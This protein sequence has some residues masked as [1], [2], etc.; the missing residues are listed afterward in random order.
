MDVTPGVNAQRAKMTEADRDATALVKAEPTVTGFDDLV[1]A[2]HKLSPQRSIASIRRG[3]RHNARQLDDDGLWT[4]RYDDLVGPSHGLLDR[5]PEQFDQLW[6]D[7]A[8]IT[9]PTLLLLGGSSNM[10]EPTMSNDSAD[11]FGISGSKPLPE[12]VTLFTARTRSE[13]L[14]Y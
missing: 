7:V 13:W 11:W 2:A 3:V 1:A 5:G 8:R 14:K 6:D 4:W 9:S 10:S 12:L